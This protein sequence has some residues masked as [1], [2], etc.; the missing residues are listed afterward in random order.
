M[1]EAPQNKT[2]DISRSMSLGARADGVRGD[3][4]LDST[5]DSSHAAPLAS[6]HSPRGRAFSARLLKHTLSAR[7]S[8]YAKNASA[9]TF[10]R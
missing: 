9:F 1:G 2:L 10:E 4:T 3:P 8:L 5:L 7:S 6:S